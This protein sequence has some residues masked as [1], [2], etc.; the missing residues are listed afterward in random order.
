MYICVYYVSKYVFR[1]ALRDIRKYVCANIALYSK[2]DG[3]MYGKNKFRVGPIHLCM[4]AC[5]YVC[6]YV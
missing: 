3:R 4:Y 1:I 5:M 6:M 2:F